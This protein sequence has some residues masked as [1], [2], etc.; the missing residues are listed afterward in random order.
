MILIIAAPLPFRLISRHTH[1]RQIRR[2]RW[3]ERASPVPPRRALG[4]HYERFIATASRHYL[5]L[6]DFACHSNA[7]AAYRD[8]HGQL[9]LRKSFLKISPRAHLYFIFYFSMVFTS[10]HLASFISITRYS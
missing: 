3:P 9:A 2:P 4:L 7:A 5:S 1:F 6:L 10:S 8:R